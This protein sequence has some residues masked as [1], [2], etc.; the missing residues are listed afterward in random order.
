LN[1]RCSGKRLL[2]YGCGFGD[3][4]IFPAKQGAFVCGVDISPASI[5]VA[6]ERAIREGVADRITLS[7]GYCENLRF[8]DDSF[9]LVFSAGVLSCLD[10]GKAYAEIARVLKPD[11]QVIIVDTLGHNPILNR[12]RAAKVKTGERTQRQ[13]GNILRMD[14]L[15]MAQDYVRGSKVHFFGIATLALDRA[16]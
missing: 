11:G 14:D 1:S 5:D 9:D 12:R 16:T 2:D 6:K 10:H 13:A 7:V 4:S 15:S 8:G 3:Y